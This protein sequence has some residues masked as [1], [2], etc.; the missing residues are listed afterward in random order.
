VGVIVVIGAGPAG[1]AC[2][3]M[4]QGS[5]AD[6]VVLERGA[7]GEAW[8]KRYDRLQLHTVRWLSCLPGYRMPRSFGKWPTH[9]RVLEYLQRYAE[10]HALEVLTGV[11]AKRIA[12]G[13]GGWIVETGDGDLAAERVVVATGYSNVPFVPDWPGTFAGEVVHSADYRNPASSPAIPSASRVRSSALPRRIY[14]CRSSIGSRGR[15]A[16]SPSPTSRRT[17]CRRRSGPIRTSCAGA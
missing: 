12:H 13:N 15:C 17:D 5:G 8:T 7:V 3:A 1:L 6:V 11:E 14:P 10:R 2:A 4:L 9:Q 16:A